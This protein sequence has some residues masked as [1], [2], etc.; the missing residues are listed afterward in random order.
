MCDFEETQVPP[1]A[2]QQIDPPAG[3]KTL[4]FAAS[5]NGVDLDIEVTFRWGEEDQPSPDPGRTG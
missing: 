3:R 2:G 5:I 1:L 4:A